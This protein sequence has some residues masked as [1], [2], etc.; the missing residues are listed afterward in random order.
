MKQHIDWMEIM[1]ASIEITTNAMAPPAL[2]GENSSLLAH[3]DSRKE[4]KTRPKLATTVDVQHGAIGKGDIDLVIL[5]AK[6]KNN[7]RLSLI[8][9][10]F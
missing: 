4:E 6:K 9:L 7:N 10:M 5:G 2:V 3:K 1:L 8:C